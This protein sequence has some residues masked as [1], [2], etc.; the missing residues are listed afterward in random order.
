MFVDYQNPSTQCNLHQTSKDI[1][2]QT[3]KNSLKDHMEAK[4]TQNSQT[5]W[6]KKHNAEG[7]TISD[8]KLYYRAII[9]KTE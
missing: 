3:T 5:T 6:G 7:I 9:I 2:H 1:L 8:F 4:K